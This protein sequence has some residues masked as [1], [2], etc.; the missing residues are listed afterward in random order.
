MCVC[1]YVQIYLEK[2]KIPRE[3]YQQQPAIV[4]SVPVAD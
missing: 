1:V 4:S 3:K 2:H